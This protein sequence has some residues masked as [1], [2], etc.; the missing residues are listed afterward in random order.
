MA[1]YN[2]HPSWA[3]WNVAL[4]FGN[5]EGLYSMARDYI[6]RTRTRDDAARAILETLTECGIT[7][8]PDGAKYSLAKVRHA[9]RGL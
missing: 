9:I 1:G 6:R 7:A 8:T 5:D 2:G 3:Y 4:W